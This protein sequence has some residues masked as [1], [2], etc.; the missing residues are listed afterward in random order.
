[1]AHGAACGC[2]QDPAGPPH[3]ARAAGPAAA[4]PARVL[5]VA[6]PVDHRAISLA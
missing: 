5:P 1:M 3:R 6:I 4:H 2:Q